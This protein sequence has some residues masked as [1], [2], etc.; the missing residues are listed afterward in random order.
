MD[1]KQTS[2]KTTEDPQGTPQPGRGFFLRG[3]RMWGT[4]PPPDRATPWHATFMGA[5]SGVASAVVLPYLDER[6]RAEIFASDGLSP[7]ERTYARAFKEATASGER[8]RGAHIRALEEVHRG[9]FGVRSA[10]PIRST[11]AAIL[12]KA[13]DR[14]APWSRRTS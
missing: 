10:H 11:L 3:R 7:I 5:A 13:R 4:A 12:D 6:L 8:S 9:G 1:N 14:I 2:K